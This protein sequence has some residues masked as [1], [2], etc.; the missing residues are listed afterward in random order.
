MDD[1]EYY[2]NVQILNDQVISIIMNKSVSNI[3]K[4]IKEIFPKF[5]SYLFSKGTENFVANLELTELI[6]TDEIGIN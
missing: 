3:V 1:D 5:N 4:G 6:K 2:E